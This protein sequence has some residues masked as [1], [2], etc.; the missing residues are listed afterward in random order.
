MLG[1]FWMKIVSMKY[2]FLL[3]KDYSFVKK[4]RFLDKKFSRNLFVFY[5]VLNI[6]IF[7]SRK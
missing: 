5:V 7:F 6:I 3:L 4:E 2:F 1:K